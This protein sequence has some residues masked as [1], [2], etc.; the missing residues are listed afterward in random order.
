MP[1]IQNKIIQW[2]NLPYQEE[3]NRIVTNEILAD[4][5]KQRQ[6]EVTQTTAKNTS[7]KKPATKN[8]RNDVEQPKK[9]HQVESPK[10]MGNPKSPTNSTADILNE[11]SKPKVNYTVKPNLKPESPNQFSGKQF[12]YQNSIQYD[13]EKRVSKT[14][15]RNSFA[16]FNVDYTKRLT[17]PNT[18]NSIRNNYVFKAGEVSRIISK[19]FKVPSIFSV[20]ELSGGKKFENALIDEFKSK[21]VFSYHYRIQYDSK[22]YYAQIFTGWNINNY[23]YVTSVPTKKKRYMAT[24]LYDINQKE[25]IIHFS[26][27]FPRIKETWESM[28]SDILNVWELSTTK[29][30]C[31]RISIAGDFNKEP[32]EVLQ[33]FPEMTAMLCDNSRKTTTGDNSFD[34]I[35]VENDYY[36]ISD[37]SIL[38]GVAFTHYPIFAEITEK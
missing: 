22:E 24:I 13:R 27:H 1:D 3:L 4:L 23:K 5:G 31:S 33:A 25:N 21:G 6:V 2:L 15:T 35:L 32:Q 19:D 29:H 30:E 28:A 17:D 34:N 14:N 37:S 10:Q 38:E 12:S 11:E 36:R 16:S 8:S 18:N 26:A 20:V 7:A 9:I